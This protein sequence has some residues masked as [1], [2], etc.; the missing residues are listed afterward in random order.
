MTLLISDPRHQR[1]SGRSAPKSFNQ[2]RAPPSLPNS[3]NRLVFCMFAAP[4]GLLVAP[5]GEVVSLSA[6][7]TAPR[8]GVA[9]AGE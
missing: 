5:P 7:S 6:W 3:F 4:V 9:W 2:V 8:E 1:S